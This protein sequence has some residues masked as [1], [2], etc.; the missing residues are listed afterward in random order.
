MSQQTP[1]ER[2][3][4]LVLL[5]LTRTTLTPQPL[6]LI[7]AQQPLDDTLADRRRCW[8][9]REGRFVSENV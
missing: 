3:E 4:P 5:D 2:R 7:F 8:V 1:I 6:V 9:I